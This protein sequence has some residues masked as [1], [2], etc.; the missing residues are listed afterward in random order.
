MHAQHTVVDYGS[1]G[2]VVEEFAAR[3]PR[4]RV[5]ILVH[6]LVVEAVDLRDL[7]RLV[8]AA[9]QRDAVRIFGL[10]QEQLSD[11]LE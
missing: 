6:A 10:E 8:I 11:G 9:Q 2:Q 7:S 5:A 1:D 4:I 3:L